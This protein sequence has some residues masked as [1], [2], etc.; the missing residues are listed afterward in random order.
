MGDSDGG[1]DD[2]ELDCGFLTGHTAL[3]RGSGFFGD[4]VFAQFVRLARGDFCAGLRDGFG[5]GSGRLLDFDGSRNVLEV[6][7]LLLEGDSDGLGLELSLRT[8]R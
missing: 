8:G 4:T 1:G 5:G 6:E 2:A 3:L 7:V